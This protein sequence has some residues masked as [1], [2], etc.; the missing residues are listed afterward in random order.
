VPVPDFKIHIQVD[1]NLSIAIFL[2]RDK[3][4]HSLLQTKDLITAKP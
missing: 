1:K 4:L 2:N 3:F